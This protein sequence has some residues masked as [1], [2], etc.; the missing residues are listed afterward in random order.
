MPAKDADNELMTLVV[1]GKAMLAVDICGIELARADG[2]AL[3]PFEAG[4]H[5]AVRTPNGG[6]RHYSLSNDPAETHR[7]VLGIKAERD[8]GGGSAA[9]VEDLA[10]GDAIQ[11]SSPQNDFQLVPAPAYILIAG[12]IGITPIMAMAR[13]LRRTRT[14]FK[15]IYCTRTPETTA[16]GDELAGADFADHVTLHHD[17]GD[18]A[19]A[20]DFWDLFETPGKAHVYC[21]GP[22][23]LMEEV[24]GVSGHWPPGA[25]HF[26]D[27]ASDAAAPQANDTAFVVRRA[28]TGDVFAVPADRSILEALRSAGENPPTS[29]ESG[30]CGTC[31]TA[32]ISGR[33]DHRDLVLEESEKKDHIMI[34]VSRA[35]SDE[36]VLDW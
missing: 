26:E 30:T 3:P 11:V 1:T 28:G 33:A 29:C 16:F 27:F 17:Q 10:E 21:C 7:Y 9:M 36:L 14:P 32:L 4:A 2:S 6:M 23:T 13:Q 15:L 12:G 34:C 24:R 31:K 8:G 35:L 22:S 25:I 18:P 5:I 20:Y 19:Q